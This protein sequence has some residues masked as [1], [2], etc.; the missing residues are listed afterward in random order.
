MV[1]DDR[2]QVV[3][4]RRRVGA[5]RLVKVVQQEGG[6]VQAGQGEVDVGVDLGAGPRAPSGQ[7][8]RDDIARHISI[9]VHTLCKSNLMR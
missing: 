2:R 4:A 8:G 3:E 9:C 7:R 6:H 1:D 5:P